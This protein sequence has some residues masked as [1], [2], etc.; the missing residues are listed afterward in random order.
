MSE[1]MSSISQLIDMSRDEF[2]QHVKE[3]PNRTELDGL[4]K[5]FE[6][7]Y[8]KVGVVKDGL[9]EMKRTGKYKEP[10]TPESV[11]KSLADLYSVLMILEEKCTVIVEEQKSRS[12]SVKS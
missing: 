3:I 5:L 8:Q 4:K 10:A 11:D 2:T 9:L 7:E 12:V 6:V 1:V